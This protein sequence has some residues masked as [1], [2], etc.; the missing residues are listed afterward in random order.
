MHVHIYFVAQSMKLLGLIQRTHRPQAVEAI[1]LVAIAAL[2]TSAFA[3]A[4]IDIAVAR[5]F[6]SAADGDH[7]PL[8]RQLPWSWF[9][10]LGPFI[11]IS[12]VVIGLLALFSGRFKNNGFWRMSGIFLILSVLL[13]P[14]LIVNPIF[15]D[16]WDRPRPRDV[17]QFGGALQYTPAPLPGEGGD[18]FPCDQ[19]SLGYLY[20]S[21]WW[22]WKR[23]R[24]ALA[25]AFLALGLVVGLALG[26]GRMAAGEHFLSDVLWSALLA[27]GL[28]HILYYCVL[29]I[30]QQG[31][32]PI[33]SLPGKRVMAL[34]LILAAVARFPHGER[35]TMHINPSHLPQ[36]P[37]VLEV[38]AR[39]A[40]IEI[41]IGDNSKPQIV[42]RGELHGLGLPANRLEA[43]TA[44]R[45][46]PV[47]TLSYR[48][49]QEGW[50]TDPNASATIHVP[51]GA[52]TRIAVR[53]EQGNI[54]VIDTTTD[55]VV[56]SGKIL[57]NLQTQDG[58]VQQGELA[59]LASE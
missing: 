32:S 45:T 38:T 7:W 37:Q 6:F 24:P 5:V 48:I 36:P 10:R 40:N 39:A 28:A 44:F 23:R 29:R 41:L 53:L 1:V 49:Q 47:A 33:A 30:P 27:M 52:L 25:R 15:K 50:V 43:S 42:L 57:L 54:R 51:V 4:P 8:A 11:T 34:L 46:E 20:A 35:F 12:L 9:H 19:C 14:G 55:H 59:G 17:V 56:K 58:N 22:L 3:A 18:S 2:I 21:G 26:L 13:G 16:H 31:T